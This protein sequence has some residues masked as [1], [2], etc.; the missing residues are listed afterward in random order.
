MAMKEWTAT[1]L[2]AVADD[3]SYVANQL[4]ATAAQMQEKEIHAL[5]L[6]AEAAFGVYRATLVKLGG[7]VESE[8][9]DQYRASQMGTLPRWKINKKIVEA[10]KIAQAD[11]QAKGIAPKK[12]ATKKSSK[13]KAP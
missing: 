4:R 11:L 3:L 9:R 10:R 5:V 8:F 12:K 2:V 13:R 1:E 7:D 6:Q